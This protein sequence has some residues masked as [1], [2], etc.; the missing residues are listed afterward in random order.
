MKDNEININ[1]Y[2]YVTIHKEDLPTTIESDDIAS[3]S[4]TMI[5]KR[6][7]R[8]E[9]IAREEEK[10]TMET[11][12]KINALKKELMAKSTPVDQEEIVEEQ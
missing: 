4:H 2:K 3:L 5:E 1:T 10:R 7:L 6:D 12:E 11:Q 9:E 8:K